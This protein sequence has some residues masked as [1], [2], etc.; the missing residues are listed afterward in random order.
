M[1]R[2]GVSAL[3]VNKNQ[4][5][6]LVNL[7]SFKEI[8]FA[9]PGGGIENG[10]SLEDAAY[11]EIKE[12]LDIEKES[13]VLVGKSDVPLLVKFKTV[14]RDEGGREFEGM[15]RYFF[16]FYFTGDEKQ[17]KMREGEVRKCAWV[18]YNNLK[19]Y[20]LFENQL[21]ETSEKIKEIFEIE[22]EI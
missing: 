1:Y 6:L 8:Y 14:K 4:E 5:F 13:L 12:E 22:A 9:I 20:L 10:E 21:E 19:E 11:R 17:I 18:P 3:I 15:E 7:E 2:K 16:G